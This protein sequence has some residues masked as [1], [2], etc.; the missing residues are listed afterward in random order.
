MGVGG[1]GNGSVNIA[2]DDFGYNSYGK[3]ID[4]VNAIRHYQTINLYRNALTKEALGYG[5][6]A[7]KSIIPN[8][9]R[10]VFIDGRT[11]SGSLVA[12]QPGEIWPLGSVSTAENDYFNDN[13]NIQISLRYDRVIIDSRKASYTVLSRKGTQLNP[14]AIGHIINHPPSIVGGEILAD[15]D[16]VGGGKSS[17]SSFVAVEPPNCMNVLF[18]ITENM[19]LASGK[20]KPYLPNEYKVPPSWLSR[21]FDRYTI[22]MHT[23]V[24]LTTRACADEEL[25]YDYR[26]LSDHQPKWYHNIQ[27]NEWMEGMGGV[28]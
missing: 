6:L 20:I 22:D 23:M 18:N 9:G 15:K 24:T 5:V 27:S 4:T 14:F 10:G 17:S 8:G 19:G 11:E 1:G 16:F 21:S 7:L 12:F 2:T 28:E 25:F 26:L 3:D 13:E